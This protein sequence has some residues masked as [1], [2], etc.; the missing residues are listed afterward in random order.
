MPYISKRKKSSL[1][2]PFSKRGFSLAE[3]LIT[4]AILV[5]GIVF[6]FRAFVTSMS[7]AKFSQN[8]TMAC[9]LAENKIW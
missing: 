5:T 9:L 4:M 1:R 7:S 3:V 2:R 6:V 8:I